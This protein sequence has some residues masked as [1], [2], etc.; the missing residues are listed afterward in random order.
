[1]NTSFKQVKQIIPARWGPF[2][3]HQMTL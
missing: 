1:M 2:P 3:T